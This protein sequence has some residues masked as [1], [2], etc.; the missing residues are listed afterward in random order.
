MKKILLAL[1]CSFSAFSQN[2][3]VQIEIVPGA[4]AYPITGSQFGNC[5]EISSDS[6][7]NAIFATHNVV[8]YCSAEFTSYPAMVGVFGGLLD[9]E[10]CNAD[11]LV[12]DLQN[13][14][15]VI[16]RARKTPGLE[17]F[18]NNSMVKILNPISQ[19]GT[20]ASNLVTTSSA[21]LNDIFLAENVFYFNNV[22]GDWYEIKCDCYS[23]DLITLLLD[24][25]F[26]LP[27]SIDPT[28]QQMLHDN[29]NYQQIVYL[30][31]NATF[32]L[33]QIQVYPNPFTE[34]LKIDSTMDEME[35]SLYDVAG[36]QILN[37]NAKENVE[38]NSGLLLSGIY[39]L[40]ISNNGMAKTFKLVKQ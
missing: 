30:L 4:S 23:P 8:R 31:S 39:F 18:A 6:N 3:T 11:L 12:A 19:T 15:A 7:L 22:V 38:R 5:G 40:R 37:T 14:T 35:F 24:Q 29:Y 21:T 2:A 28:T 27:N 1:L 32:D 9:C 34:N 25:G 36:K 20:T 16:G 17:Y 26:I 33:T 13:Y 10:D